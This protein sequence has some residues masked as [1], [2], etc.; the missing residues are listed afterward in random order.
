[1]IKK[2]VLILLMVTAFS[3]L[4][5]CDEAEESFQLS[6]E[7]KYSEYSLENTDSEKIRNTKDDR[8][9]AEDAI[10]DQ[11]GYSEDRAEGKLSENQATETNDA[12]VVVFVC[13]EV[14]EPGVYELK[15]G[16]RI[17]DAVCAAGDFTEDAAYDYLNL[18]EKINDGIKIYVPSEEEVW[19]LKEAQKD[20]LNIDYLGAGLNGNLASAGN[21]DST[22]KSGITNGMVNINTATKEEMMTLPGIGEAKAELI[23]SYREE[24]GAFQSPQDIM[25][26]SG[27]KEGLYNKIKEKICVN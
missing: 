27:I 12:P 16:A 3:L 23:I 2:Y 13:G 17:S 26:I 24:N 22:S 15:P 10:S 9:N 21:T 4:S 5:G 1:M 14:N 18:A 11:Q 19:E 8:K 6:G 20:G 25:K 7:E